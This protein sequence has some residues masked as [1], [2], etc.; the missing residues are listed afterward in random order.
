MAHELH[1]L[2]D[3]TPPSTAGTTAAPPPGSPPP[4]QPS[5]FLGR[6]PEI[7]SLD[8]DID[9]STLFESDYSRQLAV[10]RRVHVLAK[11]LVCAL[12]GFATG[13]L[14]FALD[15]ARENHERAIATNVRSCTEH[16]CPMC[17]CTDLAEHLQGLKWL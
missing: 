2:S 7:E 8:Y 3:I 9:A 11:W 6:R 4:P 15:C 12:A 14:A 13:A 17:P 5:R 10:E 1:E 16:P